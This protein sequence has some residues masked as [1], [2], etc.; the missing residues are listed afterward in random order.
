MTENLEH[1]SNQL[2]GYQ[3]MR[4][5]IIQWVVRCKGLKIT[6]DSEKKRSRNIPVLFHLQDRT[7]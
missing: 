4:Q 2:G 1:L 5:A 7:T 6:I 3:K